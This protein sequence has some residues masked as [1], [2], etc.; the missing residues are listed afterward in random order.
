MK[1]VKGL[2]CLLLAGFLI[3]GQSGQILAREFKDIQEAEWAAGYITKMQSKKVLQGFEDGSF[4]PNQPVTR[5]EAIVT[6][7]RLMGLD[8]DAKSKS[9]ATQ[10]H[11]KDAD[12][13]DKRY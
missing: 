9:S 13:L 5:V 11:F 10:L 6:A 2:L 4:R 8:G 3:F 12:Q 1:N 7:V